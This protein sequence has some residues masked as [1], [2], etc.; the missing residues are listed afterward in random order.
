MRL[1]QSLALPAW[2]RVLESLPNQFIFFQTSDIDDRD[3]ELLALGIVYEESFV[4][5]SIGDL[6]DHISLFALIELFR[7]AVG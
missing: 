2:R 1:L 7:D 3:Q 6:G 4:V 5:V